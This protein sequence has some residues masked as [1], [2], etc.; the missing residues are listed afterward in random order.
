M[1]DPLQHVNLPIILIIIIIIIIII[2][3]N[4]KPITYI[5]IKKPNTNT[6]KIH[7]EYK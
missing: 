5:N 4:D 2:N 7:V 6:K 1:K 3:N